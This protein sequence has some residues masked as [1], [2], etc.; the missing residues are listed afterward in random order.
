MDRAAGKSAATSMNAA[1]LAWLRGFLATKTSTQDG[2]S[3]GSDQTGHGHATHAKSPPKGT[4]A[5]T[6]DAQAG[7][8]RAPDATATDLFFDKDSPV[9]TKSD[10]DSLDQ[11]AASYLAANS[12]SPITIDA[13][14]SKEGD[15]KHNKDLANAR[16]KAVA[17]YLA[18]QKVPKDRIKA[19]GHE[20]T[21]K[22]SKDELRLN[23][24]ATLAPPPPA[25]APAAPST[26]APAGQD[27]GGG[28]DVPKDLHMR[29]PGDDPPQ[30][31]DP[32]HSQEAVE[33]VVGTNT[34][35]P[36]KQVE[37]ALKDF[38]TELSK[39]QPHM[40]GKVRTTK[41]VA[42]VEGTLRKGLGGAG[43]I[44]EGTERDLDPGQ[45]AKE[46]A[47][48]LPDTIPA[49]NFNAFRK[50]KPVEAEEAGN[51]AQQLHRKYTAV[52]DDFVHKLPKSWQDTAKKIIDAG[53]EKGGS[54]AVE[55]LLGASGMDSKLQ[56]QVKD[57][58]DQWIKTTTSGDSGDKDK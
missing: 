49:E 17:E 25:A 27:K 33:H 56:G 36:R 6:D 48:A 4:E 26:P 58:I 44:K 32:L 21:D 57:F 19:T 31:P 9:L 16:A 55:Q 52:R 38:F 11:Y 10:R 29:G 50:M 37:A 34:D 20:G 7:S 8:D 3:G 2:G 54:A 5:R 28:H 46:I 47:D 39:A 42:T 43:V 40:K 1:Q 30:R 23:R 12:T 14:A 13:W 41:R 24:R 53:I 35:M 22:F 18:D 15:D 51:V 45:L